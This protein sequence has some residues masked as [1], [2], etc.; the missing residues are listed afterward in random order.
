MSDVKKEA[1]E[2]STMKKMRI[3]GYSMSE[4]GG[5]LGMSKNAVIGR[6]YRN[7]CAKQTPVEDYPAFMPETAKRLDY[8]MVAWRNHAEENLSSSQC[9]WPI[10]RDES[11]EYVFC[12]CQAI[13]GKPYCEEHHDIAYLKKKN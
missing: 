7:Q 2:I 11:G 13:P 1:T 5:K 9:Q 4:I 8:G 12:G 10:G 3:D 6:L